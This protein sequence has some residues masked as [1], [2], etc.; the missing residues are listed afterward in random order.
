MTR[1]FFE[2]CKIPS[3]RFR[4]IGMAE[5]TAEETATVV[6]LGCPSSP[7]VCCACPFKRTCR[8]R[9]Q[10]LQAHAYGQHWPAQR[11]Q[12]R[13]ISNRHASIPQHP[14]PRYRFIP[15]T[16]ELA[17]PIKYFLPFL[18]GSYR[19]HN[20][21]IET[22][23]DKKKAMRARNVRKGEHLTEHMVRLQPLDVDDQVFIQ[24]QR[25]TNY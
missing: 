19:L 25:I 7:L 14:R 12:R 2:A 20:T 21:S 11:D 8:A 13:Q 15:S 24:D 9:G 17:P 16:G 4:H 10:S 3:R 1:W 23:R 6:K 22:S 18:S 5:F